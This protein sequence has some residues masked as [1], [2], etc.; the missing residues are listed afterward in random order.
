[1]NGW[2]KFFIL[3]ASCILTLI[4]WPF[5]N[6]AGL[7]FMGIFFAIWT[8]III[9]CSVVVNLFALYKVEWLHRTL[10]IIVVLIM[11]ASLLYCFP[12][13]DNQTPFS[14]L[15]NK[16]FPTAQDIEEG[17]KRLTFNFDFVRRNVHRDANYVNQKLNDG[18]DTQQEFKKIIKK[19]QD[20]FDTVVEQFKPE[21]K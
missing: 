14:R 16:Q 15:M 11:L 19:Q 7:M 4:F 18:T 12:L 8:C 3:L 2:A 1:M 17:S 9:L 20:N 10:S 13:A 21:D 6:K 5:Y